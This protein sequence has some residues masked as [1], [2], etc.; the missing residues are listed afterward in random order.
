MPPYQPYYCRMRFLATELAGVFT[1]EPER[2][3]DDRGWFARTYCRRE[4]GDHGVDFAPVQESVSF[5]Q[6]HG[7]RRG[8]HYQAPPVWEQ[9][10][11]RCTAGAVFDVVVDVRPDSNSF[12]RWISVELSAQNGRCVFVPAGF[13]H[14]FQTLEDGSELVYLISEFYDESAQRGVRSDDPEL[15]ITWPGVDEP[16]ISMRDG[17]LPLLREVRRP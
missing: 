6:R 2:R 15:A 9:K 4:F 5:N 1:L 3:S 11:V 10:L 8:L 13:A 12:G 16:V 7:T 17:G 14:G